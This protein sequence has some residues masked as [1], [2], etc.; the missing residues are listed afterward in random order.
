[1]LGY[2]Q[3]IGGSPDDHITKDKNEVYGTAAFILSGLEI[4]KYLSQR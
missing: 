4:L 3:P 1:M 2:V